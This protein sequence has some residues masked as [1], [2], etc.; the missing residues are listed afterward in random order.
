MKLR[1][2]SLPLFKQTL[3]SHSSTP[4]FQRNVTPNGSTFLQMN[5]T[6]D[7]YLKEPEPVIEDTIDTATSGATIEP[8]IDFD[9]SSK[10]WNKNKKRLK[11]GFFKYK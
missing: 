6:K 5:K 8:I 2:Q 11:Y 7:N 1:S 4:E 3:S 10:Q 9:E